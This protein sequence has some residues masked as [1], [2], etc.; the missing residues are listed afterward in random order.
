MAEQQRIINVQ[1]LR[2]VEQ[3][4]VLAAASTADETGNVE[5]KQHHAMLLLRL[6]AL[7]ESSADVNTEYE[8]RIV[9]FLA[10]EEVYQ[11]D[12]KNAEFKAQ[13]LLEDS[14]K[15]KHNFDVL[16]FDL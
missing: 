16:T 9:D 11:N 7:E 6:T 3:D 8:Q 10:S 4:S 1:L 12:A 2:I 13:V 14:V 15:A 5:L